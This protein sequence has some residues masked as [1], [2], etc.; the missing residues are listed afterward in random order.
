M[1]PIIVWLS[2]DLYKNPGAWKSGFIKRFTDPAE[3][4]PD[5]VWIDPSR[6][7]T[8]HEIESEILKEFE[9]AG[10]NQ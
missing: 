2:H 4:H 7:K 3:L 6:R 8:T 10:L 1:V 9:Q 5:P